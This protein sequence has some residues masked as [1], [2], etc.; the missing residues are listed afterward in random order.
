MRVTRK[1]KISSVFLIASLLVLVLLFD[2]VSGQGIKDTTLNEVKIHGKHKIS[3]DIRVNDFS[4]GQKVK[5]IDSATLQQYQLQNIANLLSQQEPVFVKS[6][7]FNGLATLSFRG[8]SAAQ[9]QVLWNGVPIQNAALGI[10]DVSMLPVMMANKV[11]IVYGSSGALLGSGNVGGALLLKDNAPYFIKDSNSLSISV[12]GGSFS[13]FMGGFNGSISRNRW[14]F[15]AS[16]YGQYGID[17]YRYTTQHGAHVLMPNDTMHSVAAMLRAAYKIAEKNVVTLSAC[18]QQN[19]RDIPPALFETY[20]DKKQTDKS[21]RLLADWNKQ[22][23]NNTW[24]AKSS[25]IRDEVGYNDNAILLHTDNIAY[26]YYQEV[27]WKK[28]FHKY[29]E[30]LFFIPVQISWITIADSNKT[31][32]QDKVAAVL[33]YD[34]KHFDDRL[35]IAVNARGEEIIAAGDT[36]TKKN[37]LLPGA[38]VGFRLTDWLVLRANVQRTYRVPTLNELYYNPGGNASL[39]PEQGWSEDAGYTV[40]AGV[41]KFTFYHDLSV[42]TRDIHDWIV[43]LGGA[44]WTPHNI[45]EVHSRGVETENNLTYATG[46][47]KFHLGVNTSYVLSTT[48][49]SYIYNDGSVGKQIPYI[50]RYNGQLNIGFGYMKFYINYNH[51]YTG[52]RFT[53]TDESAYLM[54]Y[55]T[56]NLQLMY[57]TD[58]FNRAFCFTAQGNNIWNEQYQVVASRPMPGMNWLFGVKMNIL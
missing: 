42:Y 22:T 28:Q 45:A 49:A 54:P 57:S 24:Y 56:G 20:S 13:Q 47:W 46:K 25:F 52:Y 50:P 19:D 48:V 26:Q 8:A 44:I 29:G 7:G 9:S 14:Y 38:D 21:L 36:T 15:S 53:T 35:D 2:K 43:W 37:I 30:V 23:D 3:G 51:T 41:N 4:P 33:A 31:K 11:G 16:S 39:K 34:Y 27:G 17:N 10:A 5:M 32:Q 58:I 40:K 6:Y 12:G 55:N 18:Y 1:K